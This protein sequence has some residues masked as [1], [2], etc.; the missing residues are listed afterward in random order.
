[1]GGF[2][3]ER[4]SGLVTARTGGHGGYDHVVVEKGGLAFFIAVGV[5]AV[6]WLTT[7]GGVADLALVTWTG[8]ELENAGLGWAEASPFCSFLL[9]LEAPTLLLFR[10]HR[11]L[12][13]QH[14]RPLLPHPPLL[15]RPLLPT[16]VQ[17]IQ[18]LALL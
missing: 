1:M 6:A 14:H 8:S 4:G 15:V 9:F 10:T 17:P 18:S 16:P 11:L 7:A 13:S 5:A 12:V 2:R 3:D